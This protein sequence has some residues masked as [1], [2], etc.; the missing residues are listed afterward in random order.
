MFVNLSD[1]GAQCQQRSKAVHRDIGCA[2]KSHWG[3]ANRPLAEII[4]GEYAIGYIAALRSVGYKVHWCA[5][6]GD[7]KEGV[8]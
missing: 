2:C 6:C 3:R 7:G 1:G 4:Q 5:R 8:A